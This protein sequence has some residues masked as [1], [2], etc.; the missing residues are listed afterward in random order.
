MVM[1]AIVCA[2]FAWY[3]RC[4]PKVIIIEEP[5]TPEPEPE[6]EP[7][8]DEL[9][10]R[11]Y[12]YLETESKER[13][14]DIADTV[15]DL[16]DVNEV[17]LNDPLNDP[18]TFVRTVREWDRSVRKLAQKDAEAMYNNINSLNIDSVL[19]DTVINEHVSPCDNVLFKLILKQ[20][21]DDAIKGRLFDVLF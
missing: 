20:L 9:E 8:L 1:V 18:V 6:P 3:K 11:L 21:T 15:K 13:T 19:F 7:E 5:P 2:L 10:E 17:P 4:P 16:F 14:I 12:Q